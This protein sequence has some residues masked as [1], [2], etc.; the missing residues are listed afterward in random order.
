LQVLRA[1]RE[2]GIQIHVVTT[3]TMP[4]KSADRTPNFESISTSITKLKETPTQSAVQIFLSVVHNY[5]IETLFICHSKW[6][7]EHINVIRREIP[8][9]KIIDA[10]HT[11][12]PYR[13]SGG[14][15]DFSGCIFVNPFIDHTIVISNHLMNYLSNFYSVPKNKLHIIKN[16]IDLTKFTS[17]LLI[18]KNFDVSFDP[19]EKLIGFIGRLVYQ[20]DPILFVKVAIHIL[21]FEKNLRFLIAGTGPFE[22]R[23]K[24]KIRTHQLSNNFLWI[25]D[26]RKIEEA[27][28]SLDLL[29]LT[30]RYE[31]VPLVIL[32]AAASGLPIVSTDVGA[33]REQCSDFVFLEQRGWG[34]ARRLAEKSIHVLQ[35]PSQKMK[36]NPDEFD[37]QKTAKKYI[38][39]FSL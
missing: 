10:L 14:F 17:K 20:K 37:I 1:C 31:G 34:L 21:K 6:V 15:P 8:Q 7:Y 19:S 29:L 2:N 28:S 39:V 18:P 32:E 27:Y 25:G 3:D 9:L 16:G 24:E 13:V 33:I 30:S 35:N 22:K 38:E 23:M 4:Q 11:L 26:S 5:S 36:F 12:E